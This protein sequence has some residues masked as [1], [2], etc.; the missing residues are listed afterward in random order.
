MNDI[1]SQTFLQRFCLSW[2]A[3]KSPPIRYHTLIK[4]RNTKAHLF[5]SIILLIYIKHYIYHVPILHL[6]WVSSW[7]PYHSSFKK[8]IDI[9]LVKWLL[10]SLSNIMVKT[11]LRNHS[12]TKGVMNLKWWRNHSW[13]DR[14]Q[15]G[16]DRITALDYLSWTVLIVS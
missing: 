6:I 1:I 13:W 11:D 16:E 5:I 3:N 10:L 12:L 9:S 4:L 14:R 15:K 7:F 2:I 8:Y